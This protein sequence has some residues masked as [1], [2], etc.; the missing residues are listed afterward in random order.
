ML[1]IF[2]PIPE[3]AERLHLL[4]I[5][6]DLIVKGFLFPLFIKCC[7]KYSRS[8]FFINVFVAVDELLSRSNVHSQ[9]WSG[10][11]RSFHC[12]F[13]TTWWTLTGDSCSGIFR[14]NA[15]VFF[16]FGS[17]VQHLLWLGMSFCLFFYFL[18]LSGFISVQL[19]HHFFLFLFFRVR[20][21]MV[22]VPLHL[23]SVKN[24]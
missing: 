21:G 17:S 7:Y 15:N 19:W 14:T 1:M 18:S 23:H 3:I 24:T 2:F 11:A 10:H 22:R 12:S 16:G 20:M 5:S 4:F 9:G 13:L 8:I 6:G